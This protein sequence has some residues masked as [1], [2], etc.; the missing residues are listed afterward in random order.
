MEARV[1][2]SRRWFQSK[3]NTFR[4]QG[5]LTGAQME[6]Q[7]HFPSDKQ[8]RYLLYLD[9]RGPSMDM[10]VYKH[11]QAGIICCVSRLLT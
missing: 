7:I 10:S 8:G 3:G 11:E 4:G 5:A 1:E 2:G 6:S 9:K